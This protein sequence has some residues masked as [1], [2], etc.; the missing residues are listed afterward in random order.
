MLLFT[1]FYKYLSISF[2][3]CKIHFCFSILKFF[4]G[5]SG[6]LEI[7]EMSLSAPAEFAPKIWI[8]AEKIISIFF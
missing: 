8:F 6:A 4:L 5:F 2:G 1:L 7:R 3:I